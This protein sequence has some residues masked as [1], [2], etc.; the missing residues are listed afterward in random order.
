M[1]EW[2]IKAINYTLIALMIIGISFQACERFNQR[3]DLPNDNVYEEAIED[4]IEHHTGIELDL[5]PEESD[6]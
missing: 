6:G 2:I 5:T 3:V 1:G 4:I